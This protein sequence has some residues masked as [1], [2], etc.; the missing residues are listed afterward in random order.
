MSTA[1]LKDMFGQSVTAPDGTGVR[2]SLSWPQNVN[3]WGCEQVRFSVRG[4]VTFPEVQLAAVIGSWSQPRFDC[5]YSRCSPQGSVNKY[6]IHALGVAHFQEC[7]LGEYAKAETIVKHNHS[8]GQV[9]RVNTGLVQHCLTCP[10]G[11]YSLQMKATKCK[12]C[13]DGGTCFGHTVIAHSSYWKQETLDGSVYSCD[14][15]GCPG[16]VT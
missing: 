12:K 2:C 13:L 4:H 15:Q 11:K 10:R 1:E 9:Q 8:T 7:L 3:Q 16:Y 5:S 6:N 14:L